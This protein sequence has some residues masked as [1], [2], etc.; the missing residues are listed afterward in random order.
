ME[1]L[2]DNDQFMDRTG[3]SRQ[4]RQQQ[5]QDF[6]S[7]DN[8][9]FRQQRFEG[10]YEGYDGEMM[11]D[12]QIAETYADRNY[13]QDQR[14]F[15]PLKR[16]SREVYDDE[17]A[18]LEREDYVQWVPMRAFCCSSMF[19]TMVAAIAITALVL[20]SIALYGTQ[21]LPPPCENGCHYCEPN[22]TL[23]MPWGGRAERPF[24]AIAVGVGPLFSPNNLVNYTGG[25]QA[26]RL[27]DAAHALFESQQSHVDDD[28]DSHNRR[29]RL[30]G[31]G[32]D[33][34]WR[35][36]ARAVPPVYSIGA[37][38]AA[39]PAALEVD[40]SGFVLGN[41][42]VSCGGYV[43]C[44]VVSPVGNFTHLI[45]INDTS[46]DYFEV[47]PAFQHVYLQNF[48]AF[49]AIDSLN[50][51]MQSLNSSVLAANITYLTQQVNTLWVVVDNI[52]SGEAYED[53]ILLNL[54]NTLVQLTNVTMQLSYYVYNILPAEQCNCTY[55]N[56]TLLSL[57]SQIDV[58]ETT[59]SQVNLTGLN[60]T[61][62]DLNQTLVLIDAQVDYIESLLNNS[63]VLTNITVLVQEVTILQNQVGN[64]TI[65][66][67]GHNVSITELY[68]LVNLLNI[69]Q[70]SLVQNVSTLQGNVTVLAAQQALTAAQVLALNQTLV[71]LAVN[72]TQLENDMQ[73][74]L[75]NLTALWTSQQVQD[76]LIASLN[77]ICMTNTAN[78]QL[79][80]QTQQILLTNVTSLSNTVTLHTQEIINLQGN[81]SVLITTVQGVQTNVSILQ[82]ITSA[83]QVQI[84]Q[85]LQCC[86]TTNTTLYQW[87]DQSVIN[88]ASVWSQLTQVQVDLTQVNQ[89]AVQALTGVQQLNGTVVV[90]VN[91]TN[92]LVSDVATLFTNAM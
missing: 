3:S 38:D 11:Q 47:Y 83:Q 4:W 36:D 28:D 59:L 34:T 43:G 20:G 51:T 9:P 16:T 17:Q 66:V 70:L 56:N 13:P 71:N 26:C 50:I 24:T 29:K 2:V 19:L 92:T 30:P 73:F 52:T 76:A 41:M 53:Q 33:L 64:L 91:T 57:Q 61:L 7:M 62:Y 90:L 35:P 78:I 40:G 74:V 88:N 44:E 80:N 42:T 32:N 31:Y 14:E 58:I 86:N 8:E 15:R 79:L 85:A 63:G 82:N 22:G 18:V 54:T 25:K 77:A 46:G 84:D 21:H 39:R 69:T 49:E 37:G 75:V 48:L 72:V 23:V 10:D 60:Q 68:M 45:T 81:Q 67:Q 87:I 1:T 55:I 6:S 12:D 65:V 27:R 89:T 5:M